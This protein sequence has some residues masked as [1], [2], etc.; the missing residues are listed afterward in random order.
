MIWHDPILVCG[1]CYGAE[2]A[3]I[4]CCNTCNDVI[5]AYT[6]K[7]WGYNIA[8]FRQ[9]D[10]NN[11][12]GTLLLN[13]SILSKITDSEIM[14][15][16]RQSVTWNFFQGCVDTVGWTNGARNCKDREGL[17]NDGCTETGYTCQTYENRWCWGGG[18]NANSNWALGS[19]YKLP[20]N[21]CCACGKSLGI[22]I[23]TFN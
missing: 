10:V 22:M 6:A 13:Y 23:H 19:M 5:Q 15:R 21:H 17:G 1:L 14:N 2:S 4:Q 8:D 11:D 12:K 18:P 7:G 3:L 20:E 16:I 9:C